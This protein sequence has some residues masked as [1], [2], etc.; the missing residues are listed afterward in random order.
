MTNLIS[1]SW[2]RRCIDGA[3]LLTF[4]LVALF[5]GVAGAV[6]LNQANVAEVFVQNSIDEGLAILNEST[7]SGEER[8]RRFRALLV[9]VIDFKRIS[10]FTLGRYARV[11]SEADIDPFKG[12]LADF[13]TAI[14]HRN[15]DVDGLVVRVTH[16]VARAADDVI[17]NADVARP[18]AGEQSLRIAFRVRKTDQGNDVIVDVQVEGVWL[19]LTQRDEFST[20]LQEHDGSILQLAG[21]L[22]SRAG[23]LRGVGPMRHR[24][25]AR[26]SRIDDARP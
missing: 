9:T 12:A 5:S 4:S 11:A 18:T 21:E 2:R 6:P 1:I 26:S 3:L 15:L 22:K 8:E 7:V 24:T 17:V 19:V 13:V 14:L 16:S 20:Y 25:G 10:V 23:R